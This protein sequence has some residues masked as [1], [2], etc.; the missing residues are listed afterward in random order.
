MLLYLIIKNHSFVD[1]N[2]RIA[3]SIFI[4]FLAKNNYLFNNDGTKKITENELVA[5]CLM[6][7]SSMPKEKDLI[8]K[9]VMKLLSNN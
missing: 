1:G 8:I 5:V 9:I 2:K 6:I 4:W 3:A 7:A